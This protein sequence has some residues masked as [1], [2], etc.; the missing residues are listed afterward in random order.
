MIDEGD[1]H[2]HP[3]MQKEYFSKLLQLL[4]FIFPR[5]DIQLF[6]STHSSFIVSDLPKQNLIFMKNENGLCR[7]DLD[8]IRQDTFGANIHEL[9]KDALF[10]TGSL[11]GDFAKSKIDEVIKWCLSNKKATSDDTER[12]QKTVLLIGEPIIRSKLAEMIAEKTGQNQE[13]AKLEEQERYIQK[14]IQQLK[15]ENDQDQV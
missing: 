4:V 9:F 1:L 14:R 12:M 2:F 11:M 7:V 8:N 5:N 13:L 3:E 6:I 10:L 15:S